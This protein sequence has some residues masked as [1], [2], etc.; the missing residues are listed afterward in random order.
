MISIVIPA[1]NKEAAVGATVARVRKVLEDAGERDFEVIVVDDGSS[2]RTGAV[3]AENGARVLSKLQNLGYGNSLKLGI[4]EAKHDTIV[5]T[6]ADGTYPIEAIPQMLEVYRRGYHMVVGARSGA[7]YQESPIKAPLRILLRW[8]VEFTAGR[9][10]PDINSGLRV[11]SRAEAMPF[12]DH[13]CEGFSFTTSITLGYMLKMMFVEYVAIDYHKRVGKTKVK[14]LRDSLRTL[15]YIVQAILFYNPLKI[16]LALSG[17]VGLAGVILTLVG[18]VA[19]LVTPALLGTG[20]ILSAAIIFA[21]GLQAEMLR[22][23]RGGDV[24]G[25]QRKEE[26]RE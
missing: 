4:R 26:R 12:F 20:G 1:Y 6:D 5:I 2:D 21:L 23:N 11:F 10:I 22:Q 18:V 7:H 25:C 24:E 15:Q 8:L 9:H 17:A 14:L 19:G 3:A 13:L 16:F